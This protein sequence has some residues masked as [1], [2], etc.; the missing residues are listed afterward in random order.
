[1]L[2]RGDLDHAERAHDQ[3][4]DQRRR[5]RPGSTPTIDADD[6][7]RRSR[8]RRPAGRRTGS[9]AAR[10]RCRAGA[11][12]LAA[13]AA[14]RRGSRPFARRAARA[15]AGRPPAA[16]RSGLRRLRERRFDFWAATAAQ[17]RK[18]APR[19]V[20]VQTR[21]R[22]M[23]AQKPL[24]LI[25]ARNLLSS[26]STPAFLVGDLGALLYLQRGRGGDARAA[27]RGERHDWRPRTGPAS[28][29]RSAR[30][31]SPIPY[32]EIPATIAVRS[33]RPTTARFRI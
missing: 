11:G 28:S 19:R 23:S 26:I 18:P 30:T 31:A 7:R 9:A 25:L 17:H 3:P 6:T 1:M 33:K 22:R 32:D 12:A 8:S 4:D 16:A 5:L 2:A 24:E 21:V 29:G 20:P 14:P 10:P 27:L 13:C 15:A